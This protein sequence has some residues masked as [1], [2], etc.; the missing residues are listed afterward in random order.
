M[1]LARALQGA[2]AALAAVA[3]L[4]LGGCASL[5]GAK[6]GPLAEGGAA[7]AP[8][9]DQYRLE[10][11]APDEVSKLLSDFL[12]LE[13]FQKAPVTESI[14]Q[15]EL[16]RLMRAAPAQARALLET[17]GHFNAD[18]QVLRLDTAAGELPALRITVVPGPAATVSDT[19]LAVQ[20]ALQEDG[21]AGQARAQ[22]ELEAL[23]AA[24]SAHRGSEFSQARWTEAKAAL[25]N[26]LRGDGWA[27]ARWARTSARVDAAAN[28]VQWDG[29]LD[30]GPLFHIG[31]IH[32]EGLSR[33]GQ[34]TVLKLADMNRGDVYSEKTLLAFQERL[35]K[36]GLFEAAAVEI[37]P[38]PGHAAAAVVQVRVKEAPVQQATF[39]VG[40][41]ALTGPR[42][43]LEDTYRQVWGSGWIATNKFELGTTQQTWAGDLT[44]HPRD[45]LYRDLV[46]GSATRL[47]ADGQLLLSWNARIGRTQNTP[48]IERR[49]FFEFAHARIDS[50]ALSN[51]ADAGSLNYQWVYRDIDNLL[52]PT[53]GLTTSAQV[54]VGYAEGSQSVASDPIAYARGPFTRLYT[55]LTWYQPLGNAW[56]GTA[57]VEGGQIVSQS[58]IGIPDTLL[59][60]AGGDDSVRGYAARTLGPSVNGVTTGGRTLFTT[61][62]EVAHPVSSRYPAYWWATF[63]DAGDTADRVGALK[64]A[65]GYGVGLRWRSP[66]GPLRADLAYGQEVHAFRVHLSVGITF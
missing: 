61:S 42:L 50:D 5:G 38:D 14:S 55:R 51:Q 2:L 43:S 28:T 44:S 3:A 48:R 52:L 56:Y 54:A 34:D 27:A 15:G 25:L 18:V 53:Q 33:Y 1:T 49:I 17:A 11:S 60:H 32:V 35:Q 19:T 47:Y 23:R 13:R 7:A 8:V 12:D 62:V 59:F 10:L 26:R 6:D 30:S 58:A 57:R 40:Y 65:V 22:G 66:V 9:R 37:D 4:A 63:V 41:S 16:D 39:G 29:A 46:S 20:G 24:W 36:L 45:N 21:Q 31:D 64:P